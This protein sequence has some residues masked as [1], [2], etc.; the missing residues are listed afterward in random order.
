MSDTMYE[1]RHGELPDASK[2]MKDHFAAALRSGLSLSRAAEMTARAAQKHD[3]SDEAV[4]ENLILLCA[5]WGEVN[6]RKKR[7]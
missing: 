5:A 2:A 7:Q 1:V 6:G 3:A 4:L